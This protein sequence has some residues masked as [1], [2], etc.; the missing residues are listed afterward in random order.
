MKRNP[1]QFQ[2]GL[3]LNEFL[4]HYGDEDKC[5]DALFRLR[6]PD[7][8]VC[9]HCGHDRSCLLNTR[10]L[11]LPLQPA[12]LGHR[13]DHF[14]SSKLPLT[15]WFQ[16]IYADPDQEGGL[17]DAAAPPAGGFLQ[18]RL[19]HQAQADAGDGR[20]YRKPASWRP[21]A[22]GRC[23]S[24]RRAERGQAGP[25]GRRQDPVRS[26]GADQRRRPPPVHQ[27][28][29]GQGFPEVAHCR[30]GRPAPGGRQRGG[31]RRAEGLRRRHPCRMPASGR[32]QR[33]RP[34]RGGEAGVLLGQYRARQPE[35]GPAQQLSLLPAKIRTALSRRIRIPLQSPVQPARPHSKT[36]PC[37]PENAAHAGKTPETR[38]MISGN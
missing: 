6:W 1:V 13:R 22:A 26:R 21:G 38:L 28:E 2:K 29:R 27:A 14:E 17:G 12:D 9:P 36:R 34:R 31:F 7:G 24:G 5:H 16:A 33:G 8:F 30:L 11:V 3:S 10:K 20:A 23:L 15:L 35:D 32:G 37:R 25:R 4:E 19:A 18:C